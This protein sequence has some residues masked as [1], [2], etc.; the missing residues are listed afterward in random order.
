MGTKKR[1]A[2]SNTRQKNDGILRG[3]VKDIL[4]D[5][6]VILTDFH[7]VADRLDDP[8][9]P[10]LLLKLTALL[11]KALPFEK[12]NDNVIKVKH[13]QLESVCSF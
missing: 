2:L 6:A 1:I 4:H 10:S 7:R 11:Y 12:V 3:V 9:N 13:N 8:L 5:Q